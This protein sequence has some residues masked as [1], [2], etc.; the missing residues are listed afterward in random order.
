MKYLLPPLIIA[1][2]VALLHPARITMIGGAEKNY[3][4]ITQ[5][6]AQVEATWYSKKY[7]CVG[8]Y[9]QCIMADGGIFSDGLEVCASRTY[10]L[11]TNLH[12]LRGDRTAYCQ[13]RDRIGPNPA[14]TKRLDL[15]PSVFQ[16]LAPLSEGKILLDVIEL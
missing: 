9:A 11:G 7:S 5:K 6:V 2:L 12:L 14:F 15:S 13:V 4:R 3:A 8:E 16:K 10:P 1:I